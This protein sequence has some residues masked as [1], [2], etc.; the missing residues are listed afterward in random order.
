MLPKQISIFLEHVQIR[1]LGP[2]YRYE[3][4][5]NRKSTSETNLGNAGWNID[6]EKMK[7]FLMILLVKIAW[8]TLITGMRKTFFIFAA[9]FNFFFVDSNHFLEWKT[10]S[11]WVLELF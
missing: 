1:S 8:K 11:T 7:S 9:R 5:R 3:M 4:V 6:F 10:M 2:K